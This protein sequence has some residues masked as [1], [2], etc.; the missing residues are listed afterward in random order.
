MINFWPTIKL[1]PDDSSVTSGWNTNA[2][3]LTR[4]IMVCYLS[5][6]L[7][8]SICYIPSASLQ[9]HR[10]TQRVLNSITHSGTLCKYAVSRHWNILW[11]EMKLCKL[12]IRK[13]SL[14]K[15]HSRP[16]SKSELATKNC[17]HVLLYLFR[18]KN[19][20]GLKMFLVM[21]RRDQRWMISWN[22]QFCCLDKKREGRLVRN[23]FKFLSLSKW[24]NWGAID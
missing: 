13:I 15:P 1:P 23:D 9:P 4:F 3:S 20:E 2:L 7:S 8:S 5:L 12:C 22:R 18:W 24:K 6:S 10:I 17:I 19:V 16:Y 14:G 21:G 11:K